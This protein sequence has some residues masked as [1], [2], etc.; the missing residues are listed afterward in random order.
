M[1]FVKDESTR[2]QLDL[3]MVSQGLDR[4]AVDPVGGKA[5]AGALAR[6]F[7]LPVDVTAGAGEMMR[8]R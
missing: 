3:L 7:A 4:P 6:A 2:Q 8:C 5:I 1:E